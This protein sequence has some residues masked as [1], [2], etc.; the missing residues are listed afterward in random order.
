[1]ADDISQKIV[2]FLEEKKSTDI[3]CISLAG[4]SSIADYMIIASGTSQRHIQSTGE[5]LK[6]YLHEMG[7]KPIFIEG[8]PPCDWVLIDGG[9]V[10]I[11][12]FRPEVR[13]FYNLEKMWG[14]DLADFSRKAAG[15][16]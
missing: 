10:I 7:V 8:T 15:E 4:K 12:L 13:A 16:N 6:Q 9:D 5:L 3:V 1:L 11:H 2:R 14:V